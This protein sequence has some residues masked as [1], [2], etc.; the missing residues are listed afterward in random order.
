MTS[1]LIQ[2][3]TLPVEG[4]T[5]A[6]C[7]A[8]VE[9]TLKQTPGVESASVNLATEKVTVSYNPEQTG[10]PD[11]ARAVEN[12]GYALVLPK[13]ATTGKSEPA[14]ESHQE[15]NYHAIKRELILSAA[16][17]IPIMIV[18][19]ISMTDWFMRWSPFGMDEINKLLFLATTIVMVAAGKR[20]FTVAWRL[21][22]H[23]S[24]DMNTLVAVG[25]GAAYLYSTIAVLFPSWLQVDDPSAHIYFDTSATIITLILLGRM[26]EARAKARTADA[27]K[28]LIG[29]QPRTAR[30]RRNGIEMDI[31][32]ENVVVG[33]TVIV[34]PGESIPV[35]G[36][37]TEGRTSI[38]ES[39][40]TGESMPVDRTVGEKAFG[41]TI[42]GSG[43][44]E[45]RAA[46]VG[47]DTVIAHVIRL[48]E[49]AQGSK[50]PIQNLVDK[51]A[52]VFVPIVMGISLV[53]FAAWLL[54]GDVT[55]S[56]A[57][58][59]SIAVLI[60]A[61]PCALGLATPTAIMVG[62]GLGAKHGILIKNAESLERIRQVNTIVLDKTGTLTLGKPIV[63]GVVVINGTSK[64]ELLRLTA[65]VEAKSEHPLG[66]AV[67]EEARKSGTPLAT[68]REFVSASGLGVSGLVGDI[69]VAAGN[70]SFMKEQ[71]INGAE[72]NSAVR[73]MLTDGMTP[74][75]IGLN[76][77]LA[78]V[79]GV[80]D[81]VKPTSAEA[82]RRIKE[83]GLKVVMLTG[84]RL[85][86]A[87][88]VAK[89]LGIDEVIAGV[90]PDQKADVIRDLRKNGGIVA[91]VGD[92]VNDAP[93]LA[94]ADVSI[95]MGSGTDVAMEASDITLM[96]G[97]PRNIVLA[98]H[99]SKKTLTTIKQNLFWAFVYNVIGIPLAAF[100]LLNPMIAAGAMAMSS[101]SVVTNSLR[102]YRTRIQFH[103]E[104]QRK[105]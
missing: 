65:S 84:D 16:L 15:K 64:D 101:V 22:R 54:V 14:E 10:L 40:L 31:D 76:G 99:L 81:E 46:A 91:M 18:S 50:A 90:R 5:C 70:L 11:L 8:R 83:L 79:I 77:T 71:S 82:V 42:N 63:A 61:C 102:L 34:R 25:T 60:I 29:L 86:T 59:N 87:H 13:P 68:V 104:T 100:G 26:L 32:R 92:G 80:A 12:A 27:I 6:S 52:S 49:E 66:L 28:A 95:A 36:V 9:K 17:S 39:M 93:A 23:F 35:D 89:G 58:M 69:R 75:W 88:S 78:G 85:E 33:D 19:M 7:V 21:A 103:R 94:H 51:I 43:S 30:V 45:L 37:I 73:E 96:N 74:L 44:I 4:M 57:L 105:R 38:D 41:G 98:I 97:D 3:E 72:A 1:P 67:V 47:T 62:T 2:T 55:L 53:T 20:F 48:V 24:A 56:A